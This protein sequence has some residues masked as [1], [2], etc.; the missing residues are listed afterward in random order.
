[1]NNSQGI[2]RQEQIAL[3][4][5]LRIE[6]ELNLK[7]KGYLGDLNWIGGT[8]I[9]NPIKP[10]PEPKKEIKIEIIKPKKRKIEF[11]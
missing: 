8:D 2:T 4:Q 6:T 1:M 11:D 7:K 5:F 9:I 3:E 10:K